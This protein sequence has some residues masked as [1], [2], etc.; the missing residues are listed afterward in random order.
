MFIT[1]LSY[2]IYSMRFVCLGK[3]SRFGA[4]ILL[5]SW[6]ETLHLQAGTNPPVNDIIRNA[7]T[8]SQH[9]ENKT[10]RSAYTYTKVTLTQELD[11]SGHVKEHKEKVYQVFFQEGLTRVRLL[12]VNGRPPAESD[13]KE[14][15]ENDSNARQLF[16]SSKSERGDC[17]ENL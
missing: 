9:S 16:G 6:L 7:V 13:V 5:L 8:R 12:S 10:A 15:S 1:C 2:S 4:A 11:A 3:L 17:R 14:Q